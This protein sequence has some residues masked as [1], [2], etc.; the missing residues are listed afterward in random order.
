MKFDRDGK[1]ILTVSS[2][3]TVRLWDAQNGLPMGFPMSHTSQIMSALFSPDGMKILTASF[4]DTAQVWDAQTGSPLTDFA[5][6]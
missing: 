1:R 3:N 2:D 6:R 5:T 4:D